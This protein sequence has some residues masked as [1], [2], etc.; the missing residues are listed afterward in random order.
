MIYMLKAALVIEVTLLAAIVIFRLCLHPRHRDIISTGDV[1]LVATIPLVGLFGHDKNVLYGFLFIAP[2][3]WAADPTRL[4][5]R[6]VLAVAS[7]PELAEP[8]IVGGLYL[9]SWSALLALNAGSLI[10]LAMARRGGLKPVRSIEVAMWLIF[11]LALLMFARGMA[12]SGAVRVV[13]TTFVLVVPPYFIVSRAIG[14]ARAAADTISFVVLGGMCNACIALVESAKHWS[15]YESMAGAMNIRMAHMSANLAL[16]AGFLRA[17]GAFVN[18]ETLGLFC[19]MAL[20]AAIALRRRFTSAGFALVVMLL[21]TGLLASQARSAWIATAAGLIAQA[22]YDRR[23]ARAGWL[24]GGIGL[25]GAGALVVSS[26]GGRAAQL[27]GISGH[28]ATTGD[29]RQ[30]LLDRGLEEAR[31]HP[32]TGQTLDQLQVSMNDLRQGEKIIDFVNTHLLVMLVGGIGALLAWLLAWG[33]P[34][35]QGWR[36]RPASRGDP[37]PSPIA[38]PFALVGT[39]VLFLTF[40]SPVDRALPFAAISMALMSVG[41]RLPGRQPA[42]LQA[43]Q[44]SAAPGTANRVLGGVEGLVAAVPSPRRTE[45]AG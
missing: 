37:D 26:N 7:F 32:L 45:P 8:Y 42:R 19:G 17:G 2:L 28:G 3:F 18:Y 31:Q 22:V 12:P 40:T 27:V 4:A 23:W 10:A 24:V 6:Y 16:R 41:L 11:L 33:I 35:V 14:S 39:I 36:R 20:M 38:L 30:R 9:A 13:V 5:K 25:L 44:P 29:Y 34:L 15:L 1:L 21:A 43:G